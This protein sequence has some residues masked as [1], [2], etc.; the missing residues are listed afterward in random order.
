MGPQ[1]E[2]LEGKRHRKI[3]GNKEEI[4]EG[5]SRKEQRRIF[6]KIIVSSNTVEVSRQRLDSSSH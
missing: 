6:M 2:L 3:K 5:H 1:M 4:M